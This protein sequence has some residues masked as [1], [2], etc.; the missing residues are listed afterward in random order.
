MTKFAKEKKIFKE[1][2]IVNSGFVLGI[3]PKIKGYYRYSTEFVERIKYA[4]RE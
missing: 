2:G 1:E 3:D 4:N